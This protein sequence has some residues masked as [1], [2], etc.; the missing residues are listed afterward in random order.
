MRMRI[1]DLLARLQWRGS[2][3]VWCFV[4]SIPCFAAATATEPVIDGN[5]TVWHPLTLSFRG[6][7]LSE[8]DDQPNPFLDYRLQVE[9]RGPSGQ[10]YTVP[11]F[12]DGNGEGGPTGDVWRVRFTADETGIWNYQASFRKGEGLG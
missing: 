8:T 10:I 2:R 4:L 7:R 3:C 11:G 5:P 9:F 12:F 1:V 6:P